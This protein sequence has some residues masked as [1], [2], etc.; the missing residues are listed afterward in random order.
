MQV[1][2]NGRTRALKVAGV[3]ALLM[4]AGAAS[5]VMADEAWDKCTSPEPD[6]GIAGCTEVLSRGTQE[7]QR[8]RAIAFR[9]RGLS[10]KD[11]G[12]YDAAIIDYGEA[13]ALYPEYVSA[14]NDLGIAYLAKN[15]LERAI[16]AY[17]AA[18]RL[19]PDY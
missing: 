14:Y 12:D 3:A 17:S 8:D 19:D 1:D 10:Y 15:D 11:K 13:I 18:V 16:A 7:T 2:W 9:N 6:I 4:V 5:P